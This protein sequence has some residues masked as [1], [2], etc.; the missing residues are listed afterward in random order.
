MRFLD[1]HQTSE[2]PLWQLANKKT[3]SHSGCINNNFGLNHGW[4]VVGSQW[5]QT[6]LEFSP[7]TLL[8]ETGREYDP[9]LSINKTWEESGSVGNEQLFSYPVKEV[10]TC[11]EWTDS[12][13][14]QIK[15]ETLSGHLNI[16]LP[17][18]LF[19]TPPPIYPKEE[20]AGYGLRKLVRSYLEW[21][22]EN[23]WRRLV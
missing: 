17:E 11:R 19:P 5:P 15:G 22:L 3:S 6:R 1:G 20:V 21:A 4:G 14:S 9:S 10:T 13:D 23:E 8:V 16:A 7:N 2:N 18:A 12:V